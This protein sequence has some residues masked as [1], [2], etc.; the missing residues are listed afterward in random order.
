MKTATLCFLTIT[1]LPLIAS[2]T[3]TIYVRLAAWL[4]MAGAA[5]CWSSNCMKEWFADKVKK[6]HLMH[7]VTTSNTKNCSRLFEEFAVLP[8]RIQR[9]VI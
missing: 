3:C 6:N 7:L 2:N 5:L 4:A 9:Q 8:S 1:V